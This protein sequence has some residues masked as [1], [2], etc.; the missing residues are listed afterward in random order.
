M[1]IFQIEN[2]IS[3]HGWVVLKDN[4][5]D[6][7]QCQAN[8]AYALDITLSH[9][10]RFV[11]LFGT[12][13]SKH[14]MI[15][16]STTGTWARGPRITQLSR[17]RPFQLARHAAELFYSFFLSLFPRELCMGGWLHALTICIGEFLVDIRLHQV[18]I[19]RGYDALDTLN[20]IR[21][22][23]WN[24]QKYEL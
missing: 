6:M 4:V 2:R 13:L 22:T 12:R 19:G 20:Y 18:I 5:S 7:S 14:T 3:N 15:P 17:H 16:Q 9:M 11:L 23:I 10:H 8:K 1:I 24:T 21:G